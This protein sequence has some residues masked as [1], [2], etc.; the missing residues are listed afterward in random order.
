MLHKDESVR[1]DDDF[2]GKVLVCLRARSSRTVQSGTVVDVTHS[3]F[4]LLCNCWS[5]KTKQKTPKLTTKRGQT[6]VLTTITLL[7]SL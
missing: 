2:K 5:S 7:I 1:R 6:A 3:C 4:F